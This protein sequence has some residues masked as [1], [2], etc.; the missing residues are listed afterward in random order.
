[1]LILSEYEPDTLNPKPAFIRVDTIW[2]IL[3]THLIKLI[4][5][6]AFYAISDYNRSK[7]MPE[8]FQN[9]PWV[10][11]NGSIGS[12]NAQ[13]GAKW[14]LGAPRCA[15]R[16]VKVR[17]DGRKRGPKEPLGNPRGAPGQSQRGPREPKRALDEPKGTQGEPKVNQEL[18]LGTILAYLDLPLGA[19]GRP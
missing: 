11:Q 2:R 13:Y 15:Q 18:S 5:V 12:Q 3:E 19:P 17:Q 14:T 6:K 4:R 8:L 1:M 16:E 9:G 7:I 10:G